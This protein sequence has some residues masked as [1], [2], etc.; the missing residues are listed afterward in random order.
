M[1]LRVI[2]W[3]G[4]KTQKW[5]WSEKSLQLSVALHQVFLRNSC[6]LCILSLILVVAAQTKRKGSSRVLLT[7][8]LITVRMSML[9]LTLLAFVSSEAAQKQRVKTSSSAMSVFM[10][11]WESFS[12]EK[13]LLLS[14]PTPAGKGS[15]CEDREL[16][17]KLPWQGWSFSDPKCYPKTI[18]VF[19]WWGILLTPALVPELLLFKALPCCSLS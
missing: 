14:V 15:I 10:N 8:R 19:E 3:N 18:A 9:I 7:W 17:R 4:I 16:L 5:D 1:T 6:F 12:W 13:Y 11:F 2:G